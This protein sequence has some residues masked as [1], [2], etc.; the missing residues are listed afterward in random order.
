M[1]AYA[2]CAHVY[3]LSDACRAISSP[4]LSATN[5][6]G[7]GTQSAE[8]KG[9]EDEAATIEGGCVEGTTVGRRW[10]G[11]GGGRGDER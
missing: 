3:A 7:E 10:K 1:C 9:A 5:T 4:S 6:R 8:G 2:P 11:G